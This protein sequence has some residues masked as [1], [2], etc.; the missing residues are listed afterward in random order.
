MAPEI[1]NAT[2]PYE[3]DLTVEAPSNI[4]QG[5]RAKGADMG[6]SVPP[7]PPKGSAIVSSRDAER[8][9]LK[10]RVEAMDDKACSYGGA[11]WGRLLG[12]W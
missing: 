7:P 1:P 3:P 12:W 11:V 6:Q 2:I 9:I 10:R 4:I 5:S 8:D